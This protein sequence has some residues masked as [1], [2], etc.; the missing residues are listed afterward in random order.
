MEDLRGERG[1]KSLFCF[2]FFCVISASKSAA[3]GFRKKKTLV[4]CLGAVSEIAQFELK[5]SD[6]VEGGGGEGQKNPKLGGGRAG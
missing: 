6:T 3:A 5:S 1:G 2:C 4:D